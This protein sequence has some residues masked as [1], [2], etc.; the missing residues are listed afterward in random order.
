MNNSDEKWQWG[1][2]W[3]A[4]ER[5][6]QIIKM[7]KL[8]TMQGKMKGGWKLN[9]KSHDLLDVISLRFY[10]FQSLKVEK[11]RKKGGEALGV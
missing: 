4:N 1:E 9:W 3:A 8:E 6:S 7:S 10:F 2:R 5:Q 11:M